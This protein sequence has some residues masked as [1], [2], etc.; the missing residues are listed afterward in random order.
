MIHLMPQISTQQ[1]F[2]LQM[3]SLCC[4][5]LTSSSSSPH[6][7]LLSSWDYIWVTP[8]LHNWLGFPFLFFPPFLPLP[9]LSMS[10]IFSSLGHS[11][12][13]FS[14][15]SF[16]S[17]GQ[18]T[19]VCLSMNGNEPCHSHVWRSENFL[20]DPFSFSTTWDWTQI[21]RLGTKDIYSLSHLS[22]PSYIVL[23]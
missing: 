13:V 16:V 11:A 21:I 8:H 9:S 6:L 17:Q 23:I 2:D 15:H 19:W 1:V 5:K 3:S 7:S 18:V 20:Q 12:A 10:V 22:H 4:R 14:T